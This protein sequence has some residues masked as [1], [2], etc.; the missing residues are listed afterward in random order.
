MTATIKEAP[1]VGM[2][3][4]LTW[5]L[6]YAEQGIGVFPLVAGSKIPPKGS[7][8][9]LAAS[10]DPAQ[11]R[12]WFKADPTMNWG[13]VGGAVNPAGEH[14][15]WID[16]D[17]TGGKDGLA[18]LKLKAEGAGLE[19]ADFDT[20]IVETPTGGLHLGYWTGRAIRQGAN[21]LGEG[22][23]VDV[24]TDLGYVVGPGSV[25]GKG[26]YR[27]VDD[28][29]IA[30]MGKLAE[31]FPVG[32]AERKKGDTTKLEGIDPKRARDRALDYL[33]TAP[34]A[35]E[36]EGGDITTFKVAAMLKDLGCNA[37]VADDLLWEHY[38]PRCS[39]PWDAEDLRKIVDNAYGYGQNAQ[40]SAA[41]EAVFKPEEGEDPGIHP[42]AKLNQEHAFVLIGGTGFILWDTMDEHG[43][44]RT[45]L[46]S[47]TAFHQL[48]AA[49]KFPRPGKRAGWTLTEEW[50]EW[51]GRR[52]FK[53]LC[54][55]PGEVL[56]E[57][58]CNLW[59]GFTVQP[60]PGDWSKMRAH[61][62]DVICSGEPALD[63][64]LMGWLAT[65]MQSPGL[66]HEV[67]VALRGGKG[68]GKGIL[69]KCLV[70]I[71]GRHA[72]HLAN[73]KHLIG[74]FNGHLR[75]CAFIFADEAFWAGDRQHEGTL[76]QLI[77]E[78]NI[79][80]ESKGKDA[81]MW[82]NRLSVL[83]A[84]NNDWVVPASDDERRFCVLDV[85]PSHQQEHRYFDA[86]MAQMDA[87]GYEAMLHDLLAWDLSG[88]NVRDIPSTKALTDQKINSLRGPDR[89]LHDAIREGI[90]AGNEWPEDSELSV[91]KAEVYAAYCDKA[92]HRYGEHHP[93]IDK[94]F[95]RKLRGILKAGGHELGDEKPKE[96]QTR[97]KRAVFPSLP[98]AKR[99][100]SKAMR[101]E[102]DWSD[103]PEVEA[104]KV[105]RQTADDIFS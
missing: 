75:E 31:L 16:V 33:K 51:S 54:F 38:N 9:H 100:F 42:L 70:R 19:L 81:I 94:V 74:N 45:E 55:A 24:R 52:T 14:L 58:F 64:Y 30:P 69:G 44:P 77:T 25:V 34:L 3:E 32:P 83:L 95:W 12:K 28:V 96:G 40:G 82:T 62:R 5:A 97:V 103:G 80:L 73:A 85:L 84:S 101:G 68:V 39:P 91:A 15:V 18:T 99:A 88:F 50:M 7:S 26:A 4:R 23:A 79:M 13:A 17:R 36:G 46:L 67:A 6:R 89:F 47:P 98:N 63:R 57:D 22:S 20:L 37:A 11:I 56:P 76:K 53:K 43:K 71:F 65:L 2:E 29:P 27:V 86:L 87:G 60:Q 1:I 61:I 78:P 8:G 90:L 35:V 102:V 48:H 66:R 93:S 72:V 59:K 105:K 104:P 92:R 10:T 21:V 49:T 41:P